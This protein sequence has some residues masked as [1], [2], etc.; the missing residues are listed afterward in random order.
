VNH[1]WFIVSGLLVAAA[2]IGYFGLRR[3]VG[4]PVDG[5]ALL[6]GAGAVVTVA[7]AVATG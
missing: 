5:A 6:I 2:A 1:P 7:I 3:I 4:S